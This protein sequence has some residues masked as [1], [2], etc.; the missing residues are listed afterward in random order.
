MVSIEKDRCAPY[1][2]GC[3]GKKEFTYE[4]YCHRDKNGGTVF[5][6][7][8]KCVARLQNKVA[9]ITTPNRQSAP[10]TM[11]RKCNSVD[12]HKGCFGAPV[13]YHN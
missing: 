5:N 4:F 13:C 6:L 2:S 1:C 8:A 11:Y 7:C 3:R 12:K 9:K 10:C